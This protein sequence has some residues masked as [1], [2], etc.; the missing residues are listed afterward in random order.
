MKDSLFRG[1]NSLLFV[2]LSLISLTI[3][4]NEVRQ[5]DVKTADCEDC[6]MS[7]FG[8]LSIK[9]RRTHFCLL[10]NFRQFSGRVEFGEFKIVSEGID[11]IDPPDSKL[12]QEVGRLLK[13]I[14]KKRTRPFQNQSSKLSVK[15]ADFRPST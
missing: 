7:A 10:V 14:V 3:A 5:I 11:I 12:S 6:G 9:V 15:I 8:Q 1:N 13:I 4:V 2:F